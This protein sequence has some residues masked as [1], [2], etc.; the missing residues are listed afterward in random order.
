VAQQRPGA[1]ELRAEGPYVAGVTGRYNRAMC[2][3]CGCH[4][5]PA[6]AE[7]SA[8]HEEILRVAWEVAEHGRGSERDE[9][10][11]MLEIHVA[12]EET[13]LYPLLVEIGDLDPAH[14]GVLEAEHAGLKAALLAG[15]F[16]RRTYY[17]LAAHIEEEE[18]ELFPAAMF[19]FEDEAWARLAA[20]ESFLGAPAAG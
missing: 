2:D 10:L 1:L 16:D 4:E 18:M 12:A 5:I 20:T 17:E 15:T 14:C 11:G 19:G 6:I 3:H 13:A 8:E 7:L 9:L